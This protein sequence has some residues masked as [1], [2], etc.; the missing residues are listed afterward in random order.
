MKQMELKMRARKQH[1]ISCSLETIKQACTDMKRFVTMHTSHQQPDTSN[2]H[3][4]VPQ[5]RQAQIIYDMSKNSSFFKQAEKQDQKRKIKINETKKKVDQYVITKYTNLGR[6]VKNNIEKLVDSY[7]REYEAQRDV[8]TI[9]VVVDMDMFFAAVAIRDR[10]HLKDKPVAI[11]GG[12]CFFL[13]SIVLHVIVSSC[14]FL[15]AMSLSTGMSMLSTSNYVA[16]TFG[17]RSAMPGFIAKKLCPHLVFIGHE[18]EKYKEASSIVKEIMREYDPNV[19]SYSLDEFFLDLTAF[20]DREVIRRSS[21]HG[22]SGKGKEGK[23][24]QTDSGAISG[25]SECMVSGVEKGL[26]RNLRDMS[27]E[28]EDEDEDGEDTMALWS[29][30]LAAAAGAAADGPSS[31]G[32]VTAAYRRQVACEVVQEMRQRVCVATGGLTCSAGE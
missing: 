15:L 20:T 14:L 29:S 24:L 1:T 19:V 16:R 12:A 25:R 4:S 7:E 22:G 5:K 3:R 18:N 11:G 10:P 23:P 17:V 6:G 32:E 2:V 13:F 30:H 9:K 27:E 26:K 28:D 8:S 31:G 21:P